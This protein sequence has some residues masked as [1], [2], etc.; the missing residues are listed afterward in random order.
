[1]K[2][3]VRAVALAASLAMGI[4]PVAA[5]E[6]GLP[7]TTGSGANLAGIL[8]ALGYYVL[9][10]QVC[11]GAAGATPS[12]A[13]VTGGNLN[14]VVDSTTAAALASI[15][16][17]TGVNI[18]APFTPGVAYAS[19]AAGASSANVALPAGVTV[20]VENMGANAACVKLGTSNA[21][22][23]T[24]SGA[25]CTNSDYIPA[26]QSASFTVGSNTYLAAIDT[27]AGTTSLMLSGGSGSFFGGGG[28]GGGG[29]GAVTQSGTW[30]VRNV[31]NAG[32]IFDAVTGAA[33]PAN[34]LYV[35]MNVAGN[36][37]GL[38]GTANGLKVDGSAVTQP[39][40]GTYF[41]NVAS[42]V[43][44]R[45]ANTTAY[46]ANETVCLFTS[47]TV[48]APITISIAN[49]NQGKGLIDHISLLKSGSSI[50]SATFKIWL[51][52]AAPG[53][54]T[55]SQFDATSYTGPRA[56]DMPNY[57]GYANCTT[58]TVTSDT[59]TQVWYECALSNP[60][61]GNLLPFQALSGSTNINA[62]I[63]V[64]AAYTPA[65]G[66][67]FTVYASGLY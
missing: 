16:T 42:S 66:E 20:V 51:F 49:T 38:T 26:G 27:S 15:V 43:L 10:H 21:V 67:T 4:A 56:A 17:N 6:S 48:C 30:T 60:N 14:I 9:F 24:S 58:P 54:S 5:A 45:I 31:G 11:S 44:T 1:M 46:A 13:T 57:I 29:G 2:R 35:G 7:V 53:T 28:G 39:V 40:N 18:P 33:V 64:T 41:Y 65:S 61:G 22:T 32:G 63:S 34:G 59:T 3:L 62:L 12:C 23:A 37:T 8:D 36:L 47:V 19:L 52:S 25:V 55:P 50:T